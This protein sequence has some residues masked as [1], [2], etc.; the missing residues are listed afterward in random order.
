MNDAPVPG[1]LSHSEAPYP[2]AKESCDSHER[3]GSRLARLPETS[4]ETDPNSSSDNFHSV[5]DLGRKVFAGFSTKFSTEKG[6]ERGV[7]ADEEIDKGPDP[8]GERQS[9]P[10]SFGQ[11]FGGHGFAG[12]AFFSHSTNACCDL[13]KYLCAGDLLRGS[14]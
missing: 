11:S 13:K 1:A 14:C 8:N 10:Q 7:A 6:F 5:E 12:F 3:M 4:P 2:W 9:F